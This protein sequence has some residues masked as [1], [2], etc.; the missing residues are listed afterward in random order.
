M[1]QFR[2]LMMT[3]IG[4]NGILPIGYTECKYIESSGNQ[5]ID[6][7]YY[8]DK[9]SIVE[10]DVQVTGGVY[11]TFGGRGASM[12][13]NRFYIQMYTNGSTIEF[14]ALDSKEIQRVD[15]EF[16]Y[17]R[18]I[19]RI[20]VFLK[21]LYID[22][23]MIFDGTG[24]FSEGEQW[25]IF[26]GCYSPNG[27]P[28]FKETAFFAKWYSFKAFYGTEESRIMLPALNEN[29]KPCL[30]DIVSQTPFYNLGTGEFG[31]ETIDGK[32]IKPV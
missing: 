27:V 8:I 24:S 11:N 26:I 31:Y 4:G 21:R 22:E 23:T 29:G 20:N 16:I 2:N 13:I 7:H 19:L 15:K 10:A 1:S 9:D 14:A 32:Y 6:P 12:E 18:H 30:F 28:T 3:K 17:T 25:P 5:Y